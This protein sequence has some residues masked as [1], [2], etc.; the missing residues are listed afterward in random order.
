MQDSRAIFG[1]IRDY[2]HVRLHSALSY[3]RPVDYYRGNPGALPAERRRKL[4]TTRELRKQQDI[5]LQNA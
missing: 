3:P 4:G 2:N 5:K 1:I